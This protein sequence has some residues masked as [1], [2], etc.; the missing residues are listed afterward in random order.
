MSIVRVPSSWSPLLLSGLVL[1]ATLAV[2]LST[3]PVGA[4]HGKG[5]HAGGDTKQ[6]QTA[7]VVATG[8]LVTPV[9][10]PQDVAVVRDNNKGL[11]LE[12]PLRDERVPTFKVAINMADSQANA[13]TNPG[14]CSGL[15]SLRD[16]FVDGFAGDRFFVLRVDMKALGSTSD[17]KN[18]HMIVV[19]WKPEGEIFD[20]IIRGAMVSLLSDPSVEPRTFEFTGGNVGVRDRSDPTIEPKDAP[21]LICPNKDAVTVTVELQ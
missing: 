13:T 4:H 3:G 9:G 18:G 19:T 12:D 15:L 8:G 10:T 6:Q 14:D 5:G 2:L 1:M 20:L 17:G 11:I 16:K 7:A 21:R